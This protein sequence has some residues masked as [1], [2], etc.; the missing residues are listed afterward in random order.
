MIKLSTISRVWDRSNTVFL[1]VVVFS[2]NAVILIIVE[3]DFGMRGGECVWV[4]RKRQI[5]R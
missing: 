4:E 2:E 3:K 5:L 1:F